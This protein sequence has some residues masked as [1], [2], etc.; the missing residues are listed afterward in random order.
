MLHHLEFYVN[1]LASSLD[2]WG[3]F[4][5][6]RGYVPFQTWE[7]GQSWRSGDGPYLVFVQVKEPWR[8]VDNDRQA[9]GFNHIAFQA[10]AAEDL[11][12]LGRKLEERGAKI[13]KASASYLC[14]EARDA[15]VAEV[16]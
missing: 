6:K 2:F 15:I 7:Q 11:L 1:D 3:W 10:L 12:V 4:L 8:A 5:E 14:F 16:L 9:Q 13:L